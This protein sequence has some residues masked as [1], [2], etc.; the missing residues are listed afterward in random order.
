MQDSQDLVFDG[1]DVQIQFVDIDD[2]KWN[3]ELADHHKIEK[4]GRNTIF[5][6]RPLTGLEKKKIPGLEDSELKQ[7]LNANPEKVVY[8]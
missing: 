7:F 2:V 8:L 6:P 4:Y 1:S 5:N 3:D